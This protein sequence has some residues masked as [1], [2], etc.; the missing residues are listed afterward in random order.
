MHEHYSNKQLSIPILNN[1]VD[2]CV[3]FVYIKSGLEEFDLNTIELTDVATR[4]KP[5]TPER[6][7]ITYREIV[8]ADPDMMITNC[9]AEECFSKECIPYIIDNDKKPMKQD[10]Y[11]EVNSWHPIKMLDSSYN[12]YTTVLCQQ[13]KL[14]CDN[15]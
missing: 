3:L 5:T 14:W 1:C 4:E 11:H 12:I 9:I 13:L 15:N 10:H 6:N 7:G 8:Y 2:Y